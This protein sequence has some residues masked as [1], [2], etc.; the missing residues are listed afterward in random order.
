[1]EPAVSARWRTDPESTGAV[2]VL[3]VDD[4][5]AL[6]SS[7]AD[8]LRGEGMSVSE[9]IDG[10]EALDQLESFRVGV[11]VLDVNMPRLSGPELLARLDDPPLVVLVTA[12]VYDDEVLA[13]Q[14]K[15]TWFLKKP[16]PPRELI[17]IVA[18]CLNAT[19]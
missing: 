16:V 8:I 3:V 9:A 19:I 17:T 2:D 12:G 13:Q 10:L 1:M 4:D 18:K 6:R 15:I 11:M 5:D 7:V 14:R